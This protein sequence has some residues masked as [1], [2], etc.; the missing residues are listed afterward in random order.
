MNLSVANVYLGLNKIHFILVK[1]NNGDYFLDKQIGEL[2]FDYQNKNE[3]QKHLYKIAQVLNSLE[4]KPNLNL[5][6]DDDFFTTLNFHTY[7]TFIQ[8]GEITNFENFNI[9]QLIINNIEYQTQ[10][11]DLHLLGEIINYEFILSW[12][13]TTKT[14]YQFPYS[15][16][17]EKL[18]AR[19]SYFTIAN[20]DPNY[21]LLSWF[22]ALPNNKVHIILKSQI[23]AALMTESNLNLSVDIN[24]NYFTLSLVKNGAILKYEKLIVGTNNLIS[25]VATILNKS[26][27]LVLPQINYVLNFAN[28]KMLS[29]LNLKLV[30]NEVDTFLKMLTLTIS[31]FV[32]QNT[33]DSKRL[34]SVSFSGELESLNN[35]LQ[36]LSYFEK[37]GFTKVGVRTN[38][39]SIY[40]IQNTI[41]GAIFF[42][43]S[44]INNQQNP[45]NTIS[46]HF[47]LPQ[48]KQKFFFKELFAFKKLI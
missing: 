45:T 22:L 20:T 4:S 12:K 17:F 44:F 32:N 19:S 7:N 37:L 30:A 33:I 38:K 8:H 47:D 15:R 36:S 13:G 46:S 5:I 28:P 26:Q 24:G 35:R 2:F 16:K 18:K 41:S 40:Q 1:E 29:D 6:L 27:N 43:N 14:Y 10:K 11:N 23:Y 39:K 25:D 34:N 21:E 3:L 31:D 48:K 42:V 9:K